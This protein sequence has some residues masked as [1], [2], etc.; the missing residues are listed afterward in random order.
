MW[1]AGDLVKDKDGVSAAAVFYEM[2]ATLRREENISVAQVCTK[3]VVLCSSQPLE[4]H[5]QSLTGATVQQYERLCERYGHFVSDN[6]SV[7]VT[8]SADIR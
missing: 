8:N 1:S 4:Q 5:C 3:L 7:L 2:A 6:G